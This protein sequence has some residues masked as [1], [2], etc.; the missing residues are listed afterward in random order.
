M[1][2]NNGILKT[3]FENIEKGRQTLNLLS[4]FLSSHASFFES[5]E[6]HVQSITPDV[7]ERRMDVWLQ[8]QGDTRTAMTICEH[9]G[10]SWRRESYGGAE[11]YAYTS[12][13][14]EVKLT[15]WRAERIAPKRDIVFRTNLP[16]PS[17]E[18]IG[19]SA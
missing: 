4:V 13:S 19:V 2:E 16:D 8:H 7:D 3:A 10:G 9:F 14:G 11:H 17:I 12:K 6:R 1:E 5:I 18:P 15:V